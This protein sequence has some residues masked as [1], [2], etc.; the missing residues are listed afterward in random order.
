LLDYW[1]EQLKGA[2]AR[3]E[4]PTDRPRPAIQTHRGAKQFASLSPQLTQSLRELSRHE[5]ATLYMTLLACLN[6]LLHYYTGQNDIVVGTNVANRNRRE[7]E[8]LIG[9]FVNDLVM[10]T[11]LTGNPTFR[12]LLGR[13]RE[14]ALG[15]YSHQDMPFDRLVDALKIER[16]PAHHP[17]FQ[18]CFVLQ[19]APVTSVEVKSLTISMLPVENPIALF[20]LVL[21]AWESGQGMPLMLEYNTD[22]FMQTT[23]TRLLDLFKT[24]A[25]IVVQQPEVRLDTLVEMLTQADR[26]RLSDKGKVLEEIGSRSLK[27]AR[28]RAVAT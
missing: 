6:T 22:L 5:D 19:N 16:S 12:E 13:V 11:D 15:A 1:Q 3:L 25:G 21:T 8:L 9:F 26:A 17:L 4:L 27:K 28:R 10:R 24:L 20:D 23:I 18:V 7:M 2:P 14:V